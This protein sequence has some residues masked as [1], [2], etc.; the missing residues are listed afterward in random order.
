MASY[1]LAVRHDTA[2][3]WT[4]AD[5]VLAQGEFGYETDTGKIKIGDSATSWTSLSYFADEISNDYVDSHLNTDSASTGDFLSWDGSDY[6]WTIPNSGGA[7]TFTDLTATS[8]FTSPG[9]DDNATTTQLTIEDGSSVFNN[10]TK[11]SRAHRYGTAFSV[12]NTSTGGKAWELRSTGVDNLLGT[13]DLQFNVDSNSSLTLKADRS[14]EFSGDLTASGNFTSKGIDDNATSTAITID[15]NENVGIG[16]TPTYRLDVDSDTDIMGRFTSSGGATAVI[17]GDANVVYLGGAAGGANSINIYEDLDL[18]RFYTGAAERLRIDAAGATKVTGGL[19]AAQPGAGA[20][21]FAAGSNAGVT[22]QGISATAVGYQAGQTSQGNSSV[23][24][25]REAGKTTQ[26]SYA[27]AV[28]VSSANALQ[29]TGAVSVGYLAGA[30]RQQQ[31]AIAIGQQAAQTDQQDNAVAIGYLAGTTGQA[32]GAVALG[33][34]AGKTTQGSYAVAVGS[35]SGYTN[36][37]DKAV[38][39][40]REA[41]AANQGDTAVAVGGSAGNSGQNVNAVAVG[42]AAGETGQGSNSI[43]IG[44][45]AGKLNQ[46]ANGILISSS[47]VAENMTNANHIVLKSSATDYLYFDGLSKWTFGGGDVTVPNDNLLVGRTS[48]SAAATDYG[49]QVESSGVVYQYANKTGNNDLHRWYNGAGSLV[50]SINARGEGFFL[51]GATYSGPL[52]ADEII[53]DGA[54][55]VDSLQIIRAFMKLRAATADPD[56]TVEELREKLKTA[57]DDIIDQFQDQIDNMPT[58]LED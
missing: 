42:K 50:A 21:A 44:A 57:V 32:V 27:V 47:G 19:E 58:P 1:R 23:A 38:A 48:L 37:G 25:G 24:L 11:V 2:A 49:W 43:A 36:Q 31:Q 28:G 29:E 4:S 46:G 6:V 10:D 54:P 34:E 18:L 55:V 15:S 41:G 7:Q 45:L 16:A 13:G 9:I 22:S 30:G 17:G 20:G 56:S 26:G 12:E 40:G 8:S 3:N 14:A 39:I 52:K 33:R 35:S 51:G 5:P 53:Q